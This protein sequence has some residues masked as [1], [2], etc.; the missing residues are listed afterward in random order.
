MPR[1]CTVCDHQDITEINL[2]LMQQVPYRDIANKYGGLSHSAVQR[3]ANR[4]LA[5][6][7]MRSLAIRGQA[8]QMVDQGLVTDAQ[9][10]YRLLAEN[11]ATA[12]SIQQ[13]AID[14]DDPNL[15]LK[16]LKEARDSLALLQKFTI[17]SGPEVQ[18]DPELEEDMRNLITAMKRVFPQ[19]REAARALVRELEMLGAIAV[20]YEIRK[21]IAID[22]ELAGVL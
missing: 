15:A 10:V 22:G 2:D 9:M 3:H 14:S 5:D 17:K 8:D 19:H 7:D 20:A 11:F 12:R 1:S 6:S 16:A 18:G 21:S 13:D 4:H